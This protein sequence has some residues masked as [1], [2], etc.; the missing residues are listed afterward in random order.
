[1]QARSSGFEW[2]AWTATGFFS[3]LIGFFALMPVSPGA[4]AMPSDKLM[5]VIAFA[6]LV[7]PLSMIF[8]R[9][10]LFIFVGAV[11]YGLL[12]EVVQPYAGRMFELGDLWA[13]ALGAI[14][15]IGLGSVLSGLAQRV[16]QA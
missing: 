8:A 3:L 12:I 7:L 11:A 14:I 5:H 13:D 10:A 1:M 9:K 6:V 15:G 16:R 4:M 2:M